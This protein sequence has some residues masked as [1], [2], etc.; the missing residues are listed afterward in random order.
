MR[1]SRLIQQKT[2]LNEVTREGFSAVYIAARTENKEILRQLIEAKAD[3]DLQVTFDVYWKFFFGCD[4]VEVVLANH[5][6][7]DNV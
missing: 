2:D 6:A 5:F 4:L 7:V 1:A 3:L